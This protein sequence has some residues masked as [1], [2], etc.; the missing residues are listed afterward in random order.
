M[1]IFAP[2]RLF[3]SLFLPGQRRPRDGNGLDPSTKSWSPRHRRQHDS[4]RPR[5]TE[6]LCEGKLFEINEKNA[7]IKI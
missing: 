2:L 3:S 6:H 1:S 7:T 4:R 5:Q